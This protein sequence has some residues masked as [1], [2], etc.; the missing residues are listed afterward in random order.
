MSCNYNINDNCLPLDQT[1]PIIANCNQMNPTIE[2]YWIRLPSD[3][4]MLSFIPLK[5]YVSIIVHHLLTTATPFLCPHDFLVLILLFLLYISNNYKLTSHLLHS[6]DTAMALDASEATQYDRQIRLWG[7]DAQRRCVVSY[8]V[9]LWILHWSKSLTFAISL[10]ILIKI[11]SLNLFNFL[12]SIPHGI[13]IMQYCHLG[14]NYG[15]NLLS[16]FSIRRSRVLVFG[17]RG[18][19]VEVFA[20]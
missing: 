16:Y 18:L 6:R 7:L 9:E 4:A 11:W 19:A 1:M 15:L 13:D 3:H 12:V 8:C 20:L 10:F 2:Y 5:L 17:A 14:K